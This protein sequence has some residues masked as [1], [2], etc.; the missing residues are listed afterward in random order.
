M[1]IAANRINAA[2]LRSYRANALTA[3]GGYCKYCLRP[4]PRNA[5]TADHRRP[6]AA[7]GNDY[8]SNIV[9]ACQ[10]CNSAK[11]KMSER[12]FLSA[13]K[14]NASIPVPLML[15]RFTRRLWQATHGASRRISSAAGV[16]YH[17]PKR[18]A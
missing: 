9:A 2:F 16:P 4:L 7:G 1:S 5:A 15:V 6:K 13:I 3:Q 8:P 18:A 17:G 11:G 10:P 12:A 14:G